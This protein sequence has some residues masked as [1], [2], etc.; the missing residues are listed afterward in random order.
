MIGSF[1]ETTLLFMRIMPRMSNVFWYS[2][3]GSSKGF[4]NRAVDVKITVA[5]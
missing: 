5:N 1:W 3:S 4:G 2:N